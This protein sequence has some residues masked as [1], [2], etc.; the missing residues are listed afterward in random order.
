MSLDKILEENQESKT[1]QL[2]NM[3]FGDPGCVS[4]ASYLK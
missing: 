1:L 4:I 2:N 3:H